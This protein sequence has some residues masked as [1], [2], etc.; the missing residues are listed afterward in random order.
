MLASC[1]TYPSDLKDGITRVSSFET[2]RATAQAVSRRLPTAVARFRSQVR[3][4]VICGG[5]SGAGAGFIRV[6]RFPLPILIPPTASHSS[7]SIVRD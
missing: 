2:G 1:L 4:C 6:L 3:S 7:L 5:Q